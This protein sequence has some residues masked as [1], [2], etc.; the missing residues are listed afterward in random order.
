MQFTHVDKPLTIGGVTVRNRIFRSGHA[1]G[2]GLAGLGEDFIAYHVARARGGVGL[3]VLEILSV[4]PS[5]PG[6][7]PPYSTPGMADGYRR[8]VDAVAPH[9]MALFQQIWHGGHNAVLYDGRATWS[10]SDV[11]SAY[12]GGSPP[13]PMTKAMIDEIVGNFAEAARNLSQ[14]GIQ[15]AEVHAAHN[16]L[17]QQF[18][19]RSTTDAGMSMAARSRTGHAS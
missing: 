12:W 4:H 14:W 3:S 5:S 6:F 1:T 19:Q 9:G 7:L 8:L 16:Y 18:L 2:L 11:P 17:V 15:G 13:I 10:A